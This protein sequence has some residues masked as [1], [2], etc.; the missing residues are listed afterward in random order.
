MGS[1]TEDLNTAHDFTVHTSCGE[2][3]LQS[4][5]VNLFFMAPL[6]VDFLLDFHNNNY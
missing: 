4:F 5:L 2:S 3:A 6:F 1:L